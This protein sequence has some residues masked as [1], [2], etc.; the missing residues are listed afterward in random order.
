MWTM[1]E[2]NYCQY[3]Q[4]WNVGI[5]EDCCDELSTG[6]AKQ[7]NS[8]RRKLSLLENEDKNILWMN[9]HQIKTTK[10]HTC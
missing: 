6:E 4:A 8:F 3:F 2:K 1:R 7:G 9:V 10:R 5:C